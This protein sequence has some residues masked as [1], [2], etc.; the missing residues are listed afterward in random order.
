VYKKPP[1][2]RT[3]NYNIQTSK[4]EN[5]EGNVLSSAKAYKE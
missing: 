2:K 4:T 5:K 3:K 1:K